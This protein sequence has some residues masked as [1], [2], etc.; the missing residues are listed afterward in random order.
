MTRLL[1]GVA[2]QSCV[3]SG[4][5]LVIPTMLQ[6][7]VA[8]SSSKQDWPCSQGETDGTASP[9]SIPVT[10]DDLRRMRNRVDGA[11]Q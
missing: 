3:L 4:K 9:S 7:S 6:P 8:G 2:E 11:F 1:I 5:S 10:P